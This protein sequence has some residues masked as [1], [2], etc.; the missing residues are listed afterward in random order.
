M[1]S[2]VIAAGGTGGH[3][4]PALA[5]AREMAALD[6]S[7]DLFFMGSATGLEARVVATEGFRFLAVSSG[8]WHRGRPWTILTG[9]FKALRG[10]L[11]ARRA[12]RLA[13]ARG[14]L[15]TGGWASVPALLAALLG[16]IPIVLHEPNRAPGLVNRLFGRVAARVTVG[17]PETGRRFPP[18]RTVVTGVPVRKAVS[19]TAREDARRRLGLGASST[20]VL[21]MGGS[22]AARSINAAVREALPAFAA[23]GGLE[24]LWL[25]GAAGLPECSA[26]AAKAGLRAKVMGYLDD[27]GAGLAAA[28]L[29]VARAGA[30]TVAELLVARLPSVLVPYPYAAGDH[31]AANARALADAGAAVLLPQASLTR[32]SLASEVL[33]L[34]RDGGRRSAM[35]AK[36]GSLA[37]PDA[38]RRVAEETLAVVGGSARC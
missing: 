27:M 22:Q 7:L 37:R 30:S 19:E 1:G 26:A 17:D 14:V 16:G 21:V 13:G 33:G 24:L 35:A 25:C 28:D 10:T 36:A 6:P 32:A 11:E 3:V 9:G 2:V 18:R 31:Q 38:A 34:A 15:S 5:A 8:P 29:A 4:Y 20:V 23:E 12:M